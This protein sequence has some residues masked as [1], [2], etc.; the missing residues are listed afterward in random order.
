MSD[1]VAEF[2]LVLGDYSKWIIEN[3]GGEVTIVNSNFNLEIQQNA[4]DDFVTMGV[5]VIAVQPVDNWAIAAKVNEIQ[6]KGIPV[7]AINNPP[8][9]KDDNTIVA[10]GGVSP[11]F[12]AVAIDCANFIL[13]KAAG[14]DVK[15]AQICGD[16]KQAIAQQRV[17]GWQESVDKNP[18]L[19]YVNVRETNWGPEA[20]MAAAEDFLTA[21]PDLYALFQHSDCMTPGTLAG[22]KR[23]G[24][25]YPVGDSRHVMV[26]SVDGAPD[27]LQAI[28]DGWIDLTI[29]QS[30]YAMACIIAK[31][32]LMVAQ[33]IKLPEIGE[34]VIQSKPARITAENVDTPSLW[35]NYGVPH[36]EVWPD[37]LKIWEEYRFA[38]DEVII[39]RFK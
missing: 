36:D 22:L 19:K 23:V 26:V 31:G 1:F 10:V 9:D 35:G 33:G 21:D 30:P 2:C 3:A 16:M 34:G 32:A 29:D 25:L 18:N 11:R 24:K 39:D 27:G 20:A 14:K 12:E 13:E 38:G 4:M 8:M 28:R 6:A 7:F 17:T 37:T 5:D 15:V